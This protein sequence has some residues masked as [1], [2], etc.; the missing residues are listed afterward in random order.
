M[1]SK[2]SIPLNVIVLYFVFLKLNVFS[3]FKPHILT[4]SHCTL[5]QRSPTFWHQG[6]VSWKTIFPRMG[7]GGGVMVQEVM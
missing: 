4:V 6:P 7:A 3:L 1:K 5:R 2:G